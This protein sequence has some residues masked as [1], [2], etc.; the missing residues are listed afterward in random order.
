MCVI[1]VGLDAGERL[2]LDANVDRV[3]EGRWD[4][5]FPDRARAPRHLQALTCRPFLPDYFP[6]HDIYL[7]LD[8][9]TWVQRWTAVELFTAVTADGSIGVV[10]EIDR[11]YSCHYDSGLARRWMYHR[12]RETFGKQAA[13]AWWWNPVISA[14]AFSMRGTSSGWTIWVRHLE[15]G[16]TTTLDAVDQ[17][18]LNR[19]IYSHELPAV[20]LP[21]EA[22]WLCNFALPWLAGGDGAEARLVHPMLPHA[23]L[24]ILHLAGTQPK[25]GPADLPTTDGRSV[26]RWLT[27]CAQLID[28]PDAP[29][30]S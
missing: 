11:A 30:L 26:R 14:G 23:E 20:F 3:A 13:A 28:R 12:Y 1:D 7:W 25:A 4:L 15:E 16:L 24:G 19:A 29:E 8:A 6:G 22:H 21:A 27:Y 2:W 10:P 17:T 18:A 5:P 9:D